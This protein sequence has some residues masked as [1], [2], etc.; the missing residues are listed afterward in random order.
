MFGS[1][2]Y[3]KIS[4]E[5]EKKLLLWDDD[6]LF[7]N[8]DRLE[9]FIANGFKVVRYTGDLE[10]RRDFGILMCDEHFKLLIIANSSQYV[11]YDIQRRCH[12]ESVTVG[13]IFKGLSLSCLE[14]YK[15]A[16]LDMITLAYRN[17]F[18]PLNDSSA[19]KYFFEKMVFSEENIERYLNVCVEWL[20]S[21]VEHCHGYGEW[22][23]IAERK[24]E[25][26]RLAAQYRMMI[27]TQWISD[28]FSAW[29]IKHFGQLSGELCQSTPV[30]VSKALDYM[31]GHSDKFVIVVMDGMSEFDWSILRKSFGGIKYD[32]ASVF[33]MIPT[34]TSI[35][36]Q[37]LLSNKYPV[38]LLEPWSQA[39]EKNEF[40]AYAMD[41]MG[42]N[43]NQIIYGRGY[44]TDLKLGTRCAAIVVNEID[45]IVHGQGQERVGM[46]NDVNVM[47]ENGKLAN[48]VKRY[49]RQGFDVYITA[50]HGNT[51]CVGVGLYRGSGVE[52]ATRSRR[53]MV[54]NSLADIDDLKA[55]YPLVE[56]P[57]Y[58]LNKDYVYLICEGQASYDSRGER[59][60]SHG[61]IT[62]DEV[63]VPFITVRAEENNG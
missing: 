22:F 56:Y 28:S 46:L 61:G 51:P 47:A 43:N 16:N 33:A 18:S 45:D 52:T 11:P 30:L 5:Y 19:I 10:F 24:A 15:D 58:Y 21:R 37:C 2:V 31:K 59:V 54:L 7:C 60:M 8:S 35:S 17:N 3:E 55:K 23:K 41:E 48:M 44:D 6:S 12:V 36:R 53:M 34:V 38:Q 49:L 42:L 1:F 50:D 29:V 63:V 40:M 13:S 39:K 25:V 27:D 14:H 62:I 26:D 32:K 20:R 57:K 9:V 4:A